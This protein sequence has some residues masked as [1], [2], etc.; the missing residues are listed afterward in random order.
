MPRKTKKRER[1]TKTKTRKQRQKQGG[2]NF[3]NRCAY[4]SKLGK[5]IDDNYYKN[6]CQVWK[7]ANPLRAYRCL[8]ERKKLQKISNTKRLQP[9]QFVFHEHEEPEEIWKIVSETDSET[10]DE[11]NE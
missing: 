1:R 6:C 2:F 3:K 5:P 8:K 10:D 11:E 9:E 4:D 7:F